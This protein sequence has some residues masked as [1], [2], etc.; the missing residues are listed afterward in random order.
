MAVY[1]M[2]G[3]G[4]GRR[5]VYGIN[6]QVGVETRDGQIR[7]EATGDYKLGCCC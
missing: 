6:R 3:F 2:S 7:I 1:F 4:F 5:V